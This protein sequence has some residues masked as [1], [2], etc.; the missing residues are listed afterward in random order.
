[1]KNVL[2]IVL[3]SILFVQNLI[4]QNIE[5]HIVV[6]TLYKQGKL[7]SNISQIISNFPKLCCIEEYEIDIKKENIYNPFPI[8]KD[9]G[10]LKSKY[11]IFGINSILTASFCNNCDEP[12]CQVGLFEFCLAS[13]DYAKKMLLKI[14]KLNQRQDYSPFGKNWFFKRE[15]CKV[16]FIQAFSEDNINKTKVE[17]SKR[18]NS[19]K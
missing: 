13:E 12:S 8:L 14:S 4:A 5:N 18:I 1:M 15:G 7:K 10:I 2:K 3:I 16:Y 19:L 6:D 9:L 11:R 17:L